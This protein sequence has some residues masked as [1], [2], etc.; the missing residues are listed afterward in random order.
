MRSA[1][2]ASGD[3]SQADFNAVRQLLEDP[4]TWTVAGRDSIQ[5]LTKLIASSLLE[6]DGRTVDG[7]CAAAE[8]I[9]RG[10]LEFV[11]SDLDPELFQRVLLTRLQRMESG[12]ANALDEAMIRLHADLG[13]GFTDIMGHL[14]HAL[15]RL[16]PGPAERAEIAVYLR[17]LIDWLNTDPWPRDRQFGSAALT[18]AD[19]ERKLSISTTGAMGH[20]ILD[21]DALAQQCRRLV[22]LGDPGAGK[23]WLAKRAARRCAENAILELGMGGNIDDIEL[24]LYTTCARLFIAD[25]DIREAVVSS[26]LD[27]LSDLGGSRISKAIRLFFTERNAPT[28]L[29]ADSLD[30][31]RGSDERLRQADTLPWRIVLTSRPSTWNQQLT[32]DE[33]NTSDRIGELERLRYP[34]DVEAFI[35]RW[36]SQQPE[37]GN[38]LAEQIAQHPS[39]QHAATVPLILAFYCIVGSEPL[40]VFRRDLYKKVLRRILTG[41]WRGST[42]FMPD[43]D[44]CLDVLRTWASGSAATDHFSGIGKWADEIWTGRSGLSQ[45]DKVALDHVATPLEYDIDTGKTLRRF[46]HRSI[47]EHLVA[48]HIAGLAVGQAV[49]KLLPHLWYDID[50]EYAA[51]AAVAMHPQHDLLMRELARRAASAGQIP[52]D[53]SVIDAGWQWRKFFARVA[54]ESTETDWSPEIA[55]IVG[56]AR[57][58]LAR[59]ARTSDIDGAGHW[60]TSN[61]QAAGMVLARISETADPIRAAILVRWVA[62]L[63]MEPED[64]RYARQA[65]L[66]QL[67]A[68]TDSHLA[69]ALVDGVIRLAPEA[70]GK[71]QA[72]QALLTLLPSANDDT[73]AVL[74][75]EITKLD[76]DVAD[77]REVRQA[78]LVLL[79]NTIGSLPAST[80]VDSIA[81]LDPEAKDKRQARQAL[82]ALLPSANGEVAVQLVNRAARLDLEAGE[83][84]EARQTLLALLT[85]TTGTAA[86]ALA[87]R[88]VALATEAEERREACQALLAQLPS[89]SD[90]FRAALLVSGI[91]RLAA[92]PE[93]SRLV[94][95]ALL[96]QLFSTSDYLLAAPLVAGV[97]KLAKGTEDKNEARQ[98]LMAQ[99]PGTADPFMAAVLVGGI[100]RLA[101]EPEDMRLAR[102][103]LLAQLTATTNGSLAAALASGVAWLDPE[104]EDKHEARRA[105]LRLLSTANHK[106]SVSLVN[107]IA[108]LAPEAEDKREARQALLAQL[109]SASGRAIAELADR[110]VALDPEVEDKPKARQALLAGLSSTTDGYLAGALVDS[111]ITLDPE[112]GDKHRARQALLRLLSTAN[113]ETTV[114]LVN[115]IAKLAPEVD[116]NRR[117]RQALL[118]LLPSVATSFKAGALMDGVAKLATEAGERR[119]T[120][121][122]LLALLRSTADRFE[123]AVLVDGVAQLEPTVKDIGGYRAWAALPTEALLSAVRRNSTLD[124]WLSSLTLLAPLS[125]LPPA[126]ISGA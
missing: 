21:A 96:A 123:A 33:K 39:L 16:P 37:L 124:D 78:L 67:T 114:G 77:K 120:R 118:A 25:G 41:R 61:R 28:L 57:V 75:R 36:F 116:D 121:Q 34:Y 47:C 79:H 84:R 10:L 93:H 24:P 23:T 35:K 125:R 113:Y 71:H 46:I 43:P 90:S 110:M 80:L 32:I 5:T 126:P 17:T 95:Q 109:A 122:A 15:D 103:A 108:K 64:K 88:V 76:P 117:T 22:V 13:A 18:P 54:A 11:V 83:K 98:A 12:Q 91:A 68:T 111:M 97:A 119:Q 53:L 107:Q 89:T 74:A 104:I 66:A 112:A 87:D 49:E 63:A 51:P 48:E 44:A 4:R 81:N 72:R 55:D 3:L 59:V 27:Q 29:V 7:A 106:T 19:I 92:D 69:A 45:A 73:A 70:E 65:L 101:V 31:A 100:A 2:D 1:A 20:Q 30:E 85:N 38:D 102:H 6:R 40:P 115:K 50:W 82:L 99:L 14:K 86:R 52:A 60:E 105:L 8:T 58:D 26:A 42:S 94:R 62:G 9:A 56:Q